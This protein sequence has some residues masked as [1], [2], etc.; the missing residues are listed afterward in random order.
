MIEV[1]GI[2]KDT[3]ILIGGAVVVGT[4]LA[5]IAIV[6]KH[7]P[8][9]T[10]KTL[11]SLADIAIGVIMVW[12]VMKFM[13]ALSIWCHHHNA[14]WLSYGTGIGLIASIAVAVMMHS[15]NHRI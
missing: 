10:R 4:I 13:E 3:M 12:S 6:L 11:S 5:T 14:M 15:M 7:L 1:T 2:I 8:K 9:L